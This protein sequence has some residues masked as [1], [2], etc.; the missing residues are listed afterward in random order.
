MTTTHDLD[1]SAF[2][3]AAREEID[4]GLEGCQLAIGLRGEVV[5]TSSHGIAAPT[6]RFWVASATKPILSSAVWILMHEA[7]LDIT[8][9]VADFVPEFAEGGKQDVTIEHVMVMT[10]GFANAPIT[11]EDGGD[12]ARRRARFAQWQLE[13]R[14]GEAYAYHGI[15]AH[16]VLAD[17]IER[18]TGE[19]F[20]DFVERRVTAP[21][22]LPRVLGI[23]REHQ[24]DVAQ[25][26]PRASNAVRN[27]ID[28]AT[29]IE[30]GEPG[31]GASM[32][33]AELALF[34]QGLLDDRAGIWEPG[35]LA[36]A[37]GRVRCT[38]PDPLMGMPAN[39]TLGVVI[40]AGFGTTWAR[41]STAW[42]WPGLGG[43]VAFAEPVSGLSFAFLQV[44]DLD[45]VGPFRRGVK[46]SN[47]ALDLADQLA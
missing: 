42:G 35:I 9:P 25:L 26:S 13:T 1:F 24:G 40:G 23:P 29:K 36:D 33:A 15:S 45:E 18:V 6:T 44:G 41:S 32:T 31:G 19:D 28:Y 34:Y 47:L 10:S 39:R 11:P 46:F 17:L 37:L 30:V 20:R 43:Q 38:L 2:E 4:R 21:M 3:A 7:G 8:R 27:A 5:H 22:G 14:P 12:R 16:W